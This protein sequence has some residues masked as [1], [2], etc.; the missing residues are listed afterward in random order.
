MSD[1][2]KTPEALQ[3]MEA[4]YPTAAPDQ[5]LAMRRLRTRILL[6]AQPNARPADN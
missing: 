6:A 1:P 3:K 2:T 5:Q 4:V